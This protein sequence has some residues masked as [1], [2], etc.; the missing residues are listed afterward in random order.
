MEEKVTE[1]E[2][3]YLRMDQIKWLLAE[4]EIQVISRGRVVKSYMGKELVQSFSIV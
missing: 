4:T 3:I 2:V 1:I